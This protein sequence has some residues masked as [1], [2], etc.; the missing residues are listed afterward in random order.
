MFS[1]RVL[2]EK[3]QIN[4][5]IY[6]K[7]YYGD[8]LVAADTHDTLRVWTLQGNLMWWQYPLHACITCVALQGF[9][10]AVGTEDGSVY[11]LYCDTEKMEIEEL[12]KLE[13]LCNS[14]ID[15][16][17]FLLDE[18]DGITRCML[19]QPNKVS[20][21]ERKFDTIKTYKEKLPKAIDVPGKNFYHLDA[22]QKAEDPSKYLL[23]GI[24]KK[25][26]Q[27]QYDL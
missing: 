27:S 9:Q 20:I 1:Q 14:R 19:F 11:I 18:G 26:M 10:I 15:Q 25:K 22:I 6:Y 2:E 16:I 21:F 13:C 4:G 24:N 23:F 17:R 3:Y 12:N 8:S 7:I 5:T